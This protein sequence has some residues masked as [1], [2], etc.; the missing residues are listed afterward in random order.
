MCIQIRKAASTHTHP[1]WT[2]DPRKGHDIGVIKLDSPTCGMPVP[3][4]GGQ[5]ATGQANLFLGFGRESDNGPFA[6]SLLI[7]EFVTQSPKVCYQA[8]A[9]STGWV[10]SSS[11]CT[12]GPG[13]N[14]GICEGG[15]LQGF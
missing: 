15:R 7:G 9:R 13:G 3:Q 12:Q 2:G 14:G 10:S 4:L 1:L 8:N 11:F 5:Q 6:T